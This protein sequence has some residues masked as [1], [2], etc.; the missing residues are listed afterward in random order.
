MR[1]TTAVRVLLPL[2]WVNL[3]RDEMLRWLLLGPLLLALSLRLA[4]PILALRLEVAL[5]FDL[6]PFFP[7]LALYAILMPPLLFGMVVGFLLLD[8]RDDQTLLALRVTPLSLSR[9]LAYRV[10]LPMLVGVLL[11]LLSFYVAGLGVAGVGLTA[12]CLLTLLSAPLAPI[13]ALFL[14]AFAANKVQGLALAK[15]AGVLFMV[16]LI[17]Q[18]WLS[19]WVVLLSPLPTY[20]P[21]RLFQRLTAVGSPPW[22]LFLLGLAVQSGWIWLL[23][24]RFHSQLN[25]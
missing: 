12:V 5:G 6:R 17:M 7:L 9:Y 25:R 15:A 20:W 21:M 14:A 16:P 1:M 18:L 24:R 3:R 2:D 11:S 22:P 4:L 23:L 10:G 13:F 19:P 8:E